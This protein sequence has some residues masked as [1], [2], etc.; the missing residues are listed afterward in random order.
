MRYWKPPA[1]SLE[2]IIYAA[3]AKSHEPAAQPQRSKALGDIAMAM[4]NGGL[5]ESLV[6]EQRQAESEP[7]APA[8]GGKSSDLPS[9]C[10]AHIERE[11]D[12]HACY[13]L[14]AASGKQ[15]E[16]SEGESR[17]LD[18]S[19]RP[20]HEW[21]TNRK[22]KSGAA[23]GTPAVAGSEP[24]DYPNPTE[25]DLKDHDFNA[26]W[27]AIKDW[28][29]SRHNDGLYSGPTGNDVMHILLAL[30]HSASQ[31]P[32]AP[33]D[34]GATGDW[35]IERLKAWAGDE[36]GLARVLNAAIKA[37][38]DKLKG[39]LRNGT[40]LFRK[41]IIAERQL[42]AERERWKND[43]DLKHAEAEVRQLRNQLRAAQAAIEKHNKHVPVSGFDPIKID[44]TALAEHDAKVREPL[45]EAGNDMRQACDQAGLCDAWDAALAKVKQ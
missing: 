11:P 8:S 6:E 3:I 26:I 9:V 1:I 21:G 22:R 4:C 17:Q 18:Y 5:T 25:A 43:T 7:A 35:T 41:L 42:A 39:E 44:T 12:C 38:E 29:I 37:A 24:E 19:N 15:P 23:S 45:V 30:K 14:S 28:D 16:R 27:S 32:P 2:D 33:R 34:S 10:S 20:P 31:L 13:P 36:R 40:A